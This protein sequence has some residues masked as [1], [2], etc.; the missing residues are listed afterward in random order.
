MIKIAVIVAS[1][2]IG[3][4]SGGDVDFSGGVSLYVVVVVGE[5]W[6]LVLCVRRQEW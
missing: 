2:E 1:E 3:A 6:V 5:M 4:P